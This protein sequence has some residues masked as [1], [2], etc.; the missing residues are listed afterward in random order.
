MND[1]LEFPFPQHLTTFRSACDPLH[2]VRISNGALIT[3][4]VW[5]GMHDYHPQAVYPRYSIELN[6]EFCLPK[7]GEFWPIANPFLAQEPIE[8]TI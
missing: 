7:T 3:V 2:N 1:L 6:F 4:Q 5:N 8:F